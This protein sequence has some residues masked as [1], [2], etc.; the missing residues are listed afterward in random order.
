LRGTAPWIYIGIYIGI[1]IGI[2]IG[3]G[4]GV[5]GVMGTISISPFGVVIIDVSTV[6]KYGIT[7]PTAAT[8]E[9]VKAISPMNG[10]VS[11]LMPAMAPT[12]KSFIAV[13]LVTEC[14]ME[15]SKFRTVTVAPGA[16][17]SRAGVNAI[18]LMVMRLAGALFVE[19]VDGVSLLVMLPPQLM[20]ARVAA[21]TG[22]ST[23]KRRIGVPPQPSAWQKGKDKHP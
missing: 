7:V 6:E 1:V 20:R 13:S 23:G 14:A 22:I 17:C 2:G 5:I 9:M 8:G 21:M 3:I 19:T 16:T 15:W 12:R 18:P 4:I 11:K 10:P